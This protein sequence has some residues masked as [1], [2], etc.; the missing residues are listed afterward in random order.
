MP[1]KTRRIRVC[2]HCGSSDI[3]PEILFGGPLAG[4]DNKDE[5]YIC[6]TCGAR[7]VP[8]DF[9][10]GAELDDFRREKTSE[11]HEEVA[12][13]D[14][15]HIPIVPLNTAPLFSLGMIDMPIG[16]VA[17]VVDIAWRESHIVTGEYRAPFL[18]YWQAISGGRYNAEH[19]FLMD[20]SG[21]EEGK[22]NFS[23]LKK[24]IKHRYEVWLDLG[25]RNLQDL[26]DSFAMDISY[27]VASTLTLPGPG[28]FEEMYELSDRC[29]P[30]ICM[31][32]RVLW[33]REGAGPADL[34]QVLRLLDRIG[35][36]MVAVID[37]NRLGTRMGASQAL[38]DELEGAE[39][40]A[41]MGGGVTEGDLIHM[42]EIG[43][44]GALMDPF[45]PAIGDIVESEEDGWEPTEDEMPA[46]ATVLRGSPGHL[47]SD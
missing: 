18:R 32:R 41:M 7:A 46:K 23:A 22:P 1:K 10:E 26:F 39:P 17:E 42:K 2:P 33:S 43:M 11:P 40:Q 19:I 45:T 9:Y 12:G 21:I 6:R 28:L 3:V 36:E 31:D 8:L 30:C 15:M 38:L 27:A 25:M 4:V 34:R 37:M 24:L 29:V 14:F 20:L 16:K 5:N 13:R 47:P 35:F 44:R